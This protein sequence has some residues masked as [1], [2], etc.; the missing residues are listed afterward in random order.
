M[1]ERLPLTRPSP[2]RLVSGRRRLFLL[3]PAL[4]FGAQG[5]ARR[6]ALVWD[7][8]RGYDGNGD[9]GYDPDAPREA[10]VYEARARSEYR[11]PGPPSDPWG[12][13][14]NEAAARFNFPQ[15]WIRAVMRQESG[16]RLNAADGTPITSSA[17]AMGLMQVMPNTYAI[18]QQ[19]YRLGPDPFDPRN[20]IMAGTA[21]LKEMHARFGAP[22]FLAAYNAGPERV[23]GYLDGSTFLPDE[24]V[25]Y[26]AA[27]GPRIGLPGSFGPSGFGPGGF[28]VTGTE[29]AAMPQPRSTDPA[30]AAYAGGGMTGLEYSARLTRPSSTDPSDAAFAGGGMTGL[31]YAARSLR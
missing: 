9:Y 14:I 26:V 30:D 15:D 19:K 4:L 11:A 31:D 18:L 27:I 10:A 17:G 21:Y 24:T 12:P 13:Y 16:G 7:G 25:N 28:G 29:Y 22:A 6:Q 1:T 2:A 5:C 23:R 20:N 8:R 3:A